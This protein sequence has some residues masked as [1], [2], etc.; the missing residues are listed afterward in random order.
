MT[1][2][3]EVKE[4]EERLPETPQRKR[5]RF[6]PKMLVT[7]TGQVINWL[8]QGVYEVE[9]VEPV[10][11][12][13]QESYHGPQHDQFVFIRIDGKPHKLSGFYCEPVHTAAA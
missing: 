6:M 10:S 12:T 8:K 4:F 7:L 3:S 11:I 9:A 5:H 1:S 2:V 13:A